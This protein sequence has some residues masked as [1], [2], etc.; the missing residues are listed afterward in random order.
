MQGEAKCGQT[1]YKVRTLISQLFLLAYIL[2]NF[3]K[4]WHKKSREIVDATGGSFN[5]YVDKKGGS[6]TKALS[7]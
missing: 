7:K 5:T 4:F 2:S 3:W 1:F 6:V